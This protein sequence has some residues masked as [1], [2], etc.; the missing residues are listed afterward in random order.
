MTTDEKWAA[1]WMERSHLSVVG[2]AGLV[3]LPRNDAAVP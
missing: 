2:Q 3:L 1:S